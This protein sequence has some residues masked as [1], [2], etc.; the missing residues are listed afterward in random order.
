MQTCDVYM[1][2]I[3]VAMHKTVRGNCVRDPN[4]VALAS[5]SRGERCAL[6]T[7]ALTVINAIVDVLIARIRGMI[8]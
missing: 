7:P 8:P 6:R 3:T 2:K 5:A 1:S 4:R